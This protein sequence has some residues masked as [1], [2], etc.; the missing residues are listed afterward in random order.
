MKIQSGQ[1]M[2]WGIH[3]NPE[4]RQTSNFSDKDTQLVLC[5]VTVDLKVV[6]TKMV[7]QPVG[8]WYPIVALHPYGECVLLSCK[9]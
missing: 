5:Y 3:Y 9:N 4:T 6:F 8:G 7:M 1:R 2:G